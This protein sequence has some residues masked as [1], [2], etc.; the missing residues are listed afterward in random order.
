MPNIA[1][2]QSALSILTRS[3]ADLIKTA[4]FASFGFHLYGNMM[5]SIPS[6]QVLMANLLRAFLHIFSQLSILCLAIAALSA[7][8]LAWPARLCPYAISLS[9]NANLALQIFFAI[10]IF[11]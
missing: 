1:R 8:V 2:L 3:V 9:L 10:L 4:R 11:S 7:A 6:G 5:S